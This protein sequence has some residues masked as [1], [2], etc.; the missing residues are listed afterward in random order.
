[1]GNSGSSSRRR[2]LE[3]L[4][5]LYSAPDFRAL[6]V[7]FRGTLA[8]PPRT[9]AKAGIGESLGEETLDRHLPAD[10]LGTTLFKLNARSDA[11]PR[12][13]AEELAGIANAFADGSP[14]LP[15]KS[16]SFHGFAHAVNTVICG[17]DGLAL[18]LFETI[19]N[20]CAVCSPNERVRLCY[21]MLVSL[22]PSSECNFDD[23][24]F[25]ELCL[26][27]GVFPVPLGVMAL[28]HFVRTRCGVM[29]PPFM[30]FCMPL[31][32]GESHIIEREML[33]ALA[34]SST[35][36]QKP[37]W[38]RLFSLAEQG[39]NFSFFCDQLLG[40]A[41]PTIICVLD[42]LGRRFGVVMIEQWRLSETFYGSGAG[43]FLWAWESEY[44]VLRPRVR[45]AVPHYQYLNTK[46]FRS[47]LVAGLGAG[48]DTDFFRFLIKPDF[49]GIWRE[50]GLTFEMSPQPKPD[51][52]SGAANNVASFNAV[53]VE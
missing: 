35:N 36:L 43:C 19:M 10:T 44:T 47:D 31:L 6:L 23:S 13:I 45:G 46:E 24:H 28:R 14:T 38:T 5:R 34:C 51:S 21:E 20:K 1:M 49:T 53:H 22:S 29:S 2:R 39:T 37:S 25:G 33:F 16:I 41:G 30:P 32:E 12:A 8:L 18:R 52:M 15:P 4:R 3:E 48:G 26:R 17:S 40:Y 11:L 50:S 7:A 42:D 27:S 9:S